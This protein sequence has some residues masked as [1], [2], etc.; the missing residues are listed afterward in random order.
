MHI[1]VDWWVISEVQNSNVTLSW[2]L[3]GD[4]KVQYYDQGGPKCATWHNLSGSIIVHVVSVKCCK[5]GK[6]Q[7][8]LVLFFTRK[9]SVNLHRNEFVENLLLGEKVKERNKGL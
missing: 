4:T 6:K 7:Q 3:L 8:E 5:V 1:T 2:G 9:K